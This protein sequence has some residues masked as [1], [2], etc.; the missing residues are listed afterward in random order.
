MHRSRQEIPLP[1]LE[2][3]RRIVDLHRL[4]IEEKAL[5]RQLA[6]ERIRLMNGVCEKLIAGTN[7]GEQP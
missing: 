2:V 1:S 3:Q 5:M 7:P 6:E 4:A